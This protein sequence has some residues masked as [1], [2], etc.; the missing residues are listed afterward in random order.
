MNKITLILSLLVFLTGCIEQEVSELQD[1]E[2]IKYQI[3]SEKPFT[4]KLI[5]RYENRLNQLEEHYEQG[6]LNGVTK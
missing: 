1:R 5:K 6:K 3:N 2:G 4:G